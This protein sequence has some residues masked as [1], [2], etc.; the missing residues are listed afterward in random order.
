[1]Q[2]GYYEV[3]LHNRQQLGTMSEGDTEVM[4]TKNMKPTAQCMKAARTSST[5][6]G[7]TSKAFQFR[8][9][10]VFVRLYT[11]YVRTNL[12]FSAPAWHYGPGQCL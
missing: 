4:V 2:F 1:M 11:H 9:R 7:Q 5:V 6:L 8:D 12:E 3:C 10:H